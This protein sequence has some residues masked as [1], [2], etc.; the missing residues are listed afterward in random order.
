LSEI[1]DHQ[2][3]GTVIAIDDSFNLGTGQHQCTTKGFQ[4]LVEWKDGSSDWL[5]LLELKKSYPIEVT[6]YAVN[7]KIVSEAKTPFTSGYRPNIDLTLELDPRQAS[8]Y[9]SLMGVLHWCIELRWLD[10]IVEVG[11]LMSF[12]ACPS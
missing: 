4:L 11:M 2:K 1:V 10:I 5:P 3:D 12:Q 6:E 8:Y 9:A 7:K